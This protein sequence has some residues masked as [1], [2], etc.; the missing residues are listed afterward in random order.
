MRRTIVSGVVGVEERLREQGSDVDVRGVV[1]D[2]GALA[3]P[4]DEAR[5]AQFRQV[6]ADRGG[7]GGDE[8]GEDSSCSSAQ[9]IL[10]WSG[11]PAAGSPRPHGGPVPRSASGSPADRGACTQANA[12][13]SPKSYCTW[14][15]S[16]LRTYAGT[17]EQMTAI[18]EP[19]PQPSPSA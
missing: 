16:F 12:D 2:E 1:V 11:P 10:M 14:L 18:I 17:V 9:R 8:V 15:C 19:G 4:A 3:S 6:L 5:Q 13:K 7:R